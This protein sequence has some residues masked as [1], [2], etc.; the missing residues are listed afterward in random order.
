MGALKGSIA[1]RRYLVLEPLPAEHRKRLVKGLRAHAFAPLDPMAE[2]DRAWGWVTIADEDD[3]DLTAEKVFWVG[4][5][6]EQLRV[7][8]RTDVLRPP[9]SE[10]KRQVAA[11]ALSIEIEE[12]RQVSRREKRL[13]KDEVIRALRQRAF[14]RTKTIDVVW[15][16]EAGQLWFFAQSKAGN[17]LFIDHFV[18][19]FGL[20]LDVDGPARWASAGLGVDL[21]QLQRLEP[22]RELWLGFEGVRPLSS[23]AVAEGDA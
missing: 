8:L 9:S 10:V 4:A 6:G 2:G 16:L 14:P 1:V 7:G 19:S 20:K 23:D 5:S 13:L 11:R 15:N 3:A 21:K 22:T 17:E 12:G 18:K